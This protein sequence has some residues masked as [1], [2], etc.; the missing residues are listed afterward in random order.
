MPSEEKEKSKHA[1]AGLALELTD[2]NDKQ[3]LTYF[4]PEMR[5]AEAFRQFCIDA[6]EDRARRARIRAFLA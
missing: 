1:G 5:E 4:E 3:W 2:A 6:A